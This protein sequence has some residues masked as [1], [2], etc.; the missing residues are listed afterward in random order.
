[1]NDLFEM[2][3]VLKESARAKTLCEIY[4]SKSTGK[5]KGK[6]K[7]LEAEPYEI[8]DGYLYIFDP[9]DGF[10]KRLLLMNILAVANMEHKPW[11]IPEDHPRK[12]YARKI[13]GEMSTEKED[14]NE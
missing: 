12:L 9:A 4:Y 5:E 13:I 6:K 10:T 14:D 11:N 1:M 3:N 8:K 7:R 2:I